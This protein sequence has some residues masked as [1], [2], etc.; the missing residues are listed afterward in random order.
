LVV[1]SYLDNLESLCM[2]LDGRGHE[3][4][5]VATGTRAIAMAASWHPDIVVLD[6]ALP[7]MD[8]EE[9]AAAMKTMASPPFIVAFSGHHR[10]EERARS[11]GCDTF[12]L[13]PKVDQLI[14]VLEARI[15]R[16]V[17]AGGAC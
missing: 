17:S 4:E 14:T 2:V 16:H 13:K 6:L 1:E 7:D 10:R 5:G 9:V 3:L 11:A 15:E 8:G 12:V